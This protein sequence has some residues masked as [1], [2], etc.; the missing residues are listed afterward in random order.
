MPADRTPKAR[1]RAFDAMSE[2]GTVVDEN[3]PRRARPRCH[4]DRFFRREMASARVI[5]VA[6]GQRRLDDED[7]GASSRVDDAVVRTGVAGD[8]DTPPI[9]VDE[10]AAPRRHVMLAGRERDRQIAD[11]EPMR[12]VVLEDAVGVV[13]EARTLADGGRELADPVSSPGWQQHGQMA[14][15][16]AF[17]R[18]EIPQ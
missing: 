6:R 18:E 4:L 3:R 17:P 15:R 7:V 10:R 14:A 9:G 16:D 2:L 13:E 8:H 11:V 1:T 12:R 5:V